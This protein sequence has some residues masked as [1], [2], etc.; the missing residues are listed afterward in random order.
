MACIIDL[1]LRLASELFWTP[2]LM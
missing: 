2:T 1:L